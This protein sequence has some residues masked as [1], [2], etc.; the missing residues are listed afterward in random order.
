MTVPRQH[1]T[2]VELEPVEGMD[3]STDAVMA[4]NLQYAV[5]NLVDFKLT[6]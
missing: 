3:C 4:A 2:Y 6:L 1:G 5:Q